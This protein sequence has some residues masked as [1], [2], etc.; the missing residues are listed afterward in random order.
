M[1]S[2]YKYN[3]YIG[4]FDKDTKQQEM[5]STDILNT[6]RRIL[7]LNKIDNYTIYKGK[8]HYRSELQIV[9]EPTMVV[10]F[11]DT[12]RYETLYDMKTFIDKIINKIRDEFKL[13]LNQEDVLITRQEV[14]VL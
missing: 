10:E 12:N 7:R 6:I 4:M 1:N 11:I 5:S 8:G 13:A 3:I 14:Q 2:M 9:C